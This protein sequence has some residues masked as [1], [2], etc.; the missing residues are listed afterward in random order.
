MNVNKRILIANTNF[1]VREG[2]RSIIHRQ[3]G[4]ELAGECEKGE[5]LISL[6]LELKPDLIILDYSDPSFELETLKPIFALLPE[7][8]ILAITPP[9]PG[10]VVN[11]A[12][13]AGIISHLLTDCGKEE[14]LEALDYSLRGEKFFCGKILKE[15]VP[16]TSDAEREPGF[17]I[18]NGVKISAREIEIIRLVAEGLTNKEI[19]DRLCLSTHTIMTHRKNIMAKTGIN[20]SA[21]LVI[22]GLKNQLISQ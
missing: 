12:I 20:N 4:L 14:I 10:Q 1:L 15:L 18:C 22:F 11:Q 19:A 5:D 7:I 16:E 9:Q 17:R 21:A 3:N 6:C 8:Q 13:E 2:F